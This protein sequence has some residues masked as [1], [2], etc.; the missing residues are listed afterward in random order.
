MSAVMSDH[1][2]DL[3]AVLH[4]ID[5]GACERAK[6]VKFAMEMLRQG[7]GRRAISGEVQRRFKVSQPTA[8][9]V[10]DMAFDMAG[11]L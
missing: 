1:H 4:A 10:V 3:L 5:P 6:R 9:I 11:P 8:W 7:M 2:A